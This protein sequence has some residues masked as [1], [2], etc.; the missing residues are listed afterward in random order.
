[1]KVRQIK[2]VILT[3]A[4]IGFLAQ[5]SYAGSSASEKH[6]IVALRMIGHQVLLS[7]GDST[8][9]VL[10]VIEEDGRYRITIASEFTLQPSDL[11]AIVARVAAETGIAI[12][13]IIEVENCASKEIVYAYEVGKTENTD[14]VP[15]RGRDLPKECYSLLFT[16]TGEPILLDKEESKKENLTAASSPYLIAMFLAMLFALIAFIALR[17]RKISEVSN[18]NW[19]QIGNY[20]F[21]KLDTKLIFKKQRIE[22]TSKEAD[23]LLLLFTDLNSTVERDTI[24]NRVWGDEGDYVGRTLDVFISKLRKKLELDPLVK[25]VNIR[26]IGYKLVISSE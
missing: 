23:L 26:G 15:C 6:L 14:I 16:N 24:L 1:M 12:S 5:V 3:M 4:C 22:L 13:Y 11:T 9:L 19:I 17:K 21:D 8:S 25:I 7:A 18:P 2:A 10:P 20:F